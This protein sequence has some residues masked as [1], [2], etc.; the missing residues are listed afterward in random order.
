MKKQ[1]WVDFSGY[2]CV[3]AEN[4]DEADAIMWAAIHQAFDGKTVFDDVWDIDGI[5]ERVIEDVPNSEH[6]KKILDL[7]FNS[8]TMQDLENFWND[9]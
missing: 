5:E 3:E 7:I 8:P 1:Y 4:A 9:R 2:A 6:D